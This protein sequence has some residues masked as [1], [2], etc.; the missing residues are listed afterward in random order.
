M[1]EEF[2]QTNSAVSLNCKVPMK[3]V[4]I[5]LGSTFLCRVK[6]AKGINVIKLVN[7]I[8]VLTLKVLNF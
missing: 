5:V 7:N 6:Q 1:D 2:V 4:Y 3:S 8:N